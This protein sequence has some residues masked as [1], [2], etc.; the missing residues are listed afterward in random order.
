MV[1]RTNTSFS[2]GGAGTMSLNTNLNIK[3]GG[4]NS[5]QG[6]VSTVGTTLSRV[7]RIQGGNN[8]LFKKIITTEMLYKMLNESM[9][10]NTD[11]DI[12]I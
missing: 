11:T 3:T 6:L 5:K 2:A 4:G 8:Y 7:R 1:G 10:T 12:Y 9:H